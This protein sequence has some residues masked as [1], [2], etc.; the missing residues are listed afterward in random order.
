[1]CEWVKENKPLPE[2]GERL[3]IRSWLA[4]R[5][6]A[7]VE[8]KLKRLHV[9]QRQVRDRVARLQDERKRKGMPEADYKSKLTALEAEKHAITER[10]N[11]LVAEEQ[12]L[13]QTL[14]AERRASGT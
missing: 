11:A 12:S 1:M 9:Q 5:K 3:T 14:Q 4:E 7:R 8:S 2:A 6:L 13:R 10:V